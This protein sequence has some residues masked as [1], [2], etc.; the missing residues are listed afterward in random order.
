VPTDDSGGENFAIW[1]TGQAR[2]EYMPYPVPTD[3]TPGDSVAIWDNINWRWEYVPRPEEGPGVFQF[4]QD[5]EFPDGH[6]VWVAIEPGDGN[7][8]AKDPDGKIVDT[9]ID[10]GD[11]KLLIDWLIQ[12]KNRFPM[13]PEEMVDKDMMV[14]VGNINLYGKTWGDDSAIIETHN[15][16]Q[17]PQYQ[18][19]GDQLGRAV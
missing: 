19:E 9:G 3:D 14:A 8:L 16:T 7:I 11:L 18:R 17:T 10:S 12:I 5:D 4:I 15:P 6:Y 13:T 1:D 2:W